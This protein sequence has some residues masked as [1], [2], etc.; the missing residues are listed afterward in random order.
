MAEEKLFDKDQD[1]AAPRRV[2]R[3][4]RVFMGRGIRG[5]GLVGNIVQLMSAPPVIVAK[6]SRVPASLT[7]GW[8]SS[9][10]ARGSARD[11]AH[12]VAKRKRRE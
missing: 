8:R 12:V 2:I 11:G 7:L 6:E 1:K 9:A 5:S 4:A 3:R 10:L